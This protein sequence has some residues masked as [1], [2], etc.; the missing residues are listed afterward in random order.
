MTIRVQQT[1][2]LDQP[3]LE[4]IFGRGWLLRPFHVMVGSSRFDETRI[5][6]ADQARGRVLT[7]DTM[8][9]WATVIAS[10]GLPM[11]TERKRDMGYLNKPRIEQGRSS[12]DGWRSMTSGPSLSSRTWLD[13]F[14]SLLHPLCP[15]LGQH[16]DRCLPS[17]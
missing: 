9:K 12:T 16:V 15:A 6:P 2:G 5:A 7:A 3:G 8:R 13:P 1:I 14:Q 4:T 11:W 10:V 17:P